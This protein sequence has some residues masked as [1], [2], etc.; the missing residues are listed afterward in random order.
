MLSP[1]TI[2]Q[3]NDAMVKE[4]QKAQAVWLHTFYATMIPRELFN[5]AAQNHLERA[6]K[7]SKEQGF[8]VHCYKTSTGG[9]T[10]I[11]KGGVVVASFEPKRHQGPVHAQ[12]S[13][14]ASVLGRPIPIAA[15][16]QLLDE[17]P[18]TAP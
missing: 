1:E 4:I 8:S 18:P 15:F 3:F 17:K 14:K 16:T 13:F 6:R 10:E 11:H 2:R 5:E 12:L 7:W 9:F